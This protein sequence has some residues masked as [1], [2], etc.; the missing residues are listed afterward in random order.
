[1]FG[2][3]IPGHGFYSINIP[4]TKVKE[5]YDSGVLTII[6]GEATEEK[7]DK[8]LKNL[9]REDW[10]FKVKK[11]DKTKFLVVFLIRTLWKPSLN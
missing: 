2:F 3:G 9:V 4:V 5:Y 10:D 8:E 7:I 11:M 6:E 1:M